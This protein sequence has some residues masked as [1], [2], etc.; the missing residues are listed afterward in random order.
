MIITRENSNQTIKFISDSATC[1]KE[2]TAAETEKY[3][4]IYRSY[5]T[6]PGFTDVCEAVI[7]SKQ[8]SEEVYKTTVP[9]SYICG[10][11]LENHPITGHDYV[12]ISPFGLIIIDLTTGEWVDLKI[13]DFHIVE[14]SFSENKKSIICNGCYWGGP[15]T[16]VL[17]DMENPLLINNNNFHHFGSWNEEINFE[18]W[19]GNSIIEC[20]SEIFEKCEKDCTMVHSHHAGAVKKHKLFINTESIRKGYY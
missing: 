4:L 17:I 13:S 16:N 5:D 10:S 1:K 9:Y 15:Y 6:K 2:K 18:C 7:I 11:F 12:F 14:Y 8:T 19:H 20:E 3:K